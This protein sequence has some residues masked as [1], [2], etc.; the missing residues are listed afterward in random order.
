LQGVLPV[1]S[2]RCTVLDSNS[3]IPVTL[4]A[5]GSAIFKR[6]RRI[7]NWRACGRWIGSA[8]TWLGCWLYWDG[9]GCGRWLLLAKDHLL[10][11]V[12]KHHALLGECIAG[13]NHRNRCV[14]A[15]VLH[16]SKDAIGCQ[17]LQRCTGPGGHECTIVIFPIVGNSVRCV[18]PLGDH[19][20]KRC[21]N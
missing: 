20:R 3:L 18:V 14:G 8:T 17:R 10:V 16:G 19:D 21:A 9:G 13:R 7:R 4:P 11:D 12:P 5:A 15:R 2:N 1:H 6:E